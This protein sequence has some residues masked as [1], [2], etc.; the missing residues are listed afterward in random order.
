MTG[1]GKRLARSNEATSGLASKLG[2]TIGALLNS[3]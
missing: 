3:D 1:G 2:V